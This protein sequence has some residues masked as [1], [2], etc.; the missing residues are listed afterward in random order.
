MPLVVARLYI[1]TVSTSCQQ[2]YKT[3]C[4][5]KPVTCVAM[6]LL[7]FVDGLMIALYH[8]VVNNFLQSFLKKVFLPYNAKN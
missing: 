1:I 2:L 7:C 6:L 3:F 8:I 4:D 5:L